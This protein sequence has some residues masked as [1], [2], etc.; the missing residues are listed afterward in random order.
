M[1]DWTIPVGI[2]DVCRIHK[3]CSEL[4][5]ELAIDAYPND[6]VLKMVQKA[7]QEYEGNKEQEPDVHPLEL[8]QNYLNQGAPSRDSESESKVIYSYRTTTPSCTAIA[9]KLDVSEQFNEHVSVNTRNVRKWLKT[10]KHRAGDK[11]IK[12]DDDLIAK[13]KS[14]CVEC[15]SRILTSNDIK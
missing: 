9:L 5:H 12:I 4:I 3:E 11:K 1:R 7:M 14:F 10:N 6:E 13:I 2:I 8:E 15:S